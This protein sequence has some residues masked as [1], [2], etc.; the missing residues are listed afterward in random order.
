MADVF[1]D[2]EQ[3]AIGSVTGSLTLE[4]A[5]RRFVELME[6]LAGKEDA[7]AATLVELGHN[8]ATPTVELG[9]RFERMD[10]A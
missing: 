10:S 2:E 3:Q 4:K 7:D 1:S 9:P 8:D 5:R 6:S